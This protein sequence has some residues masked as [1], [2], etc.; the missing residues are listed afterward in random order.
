MSSDANQPD[1]AIARAIRDVVLQGS[2]S[3]REVL[4]DYAIRYCRIF[5]WKRRSLR[6]FG[7]AESFG[8]VTADVAGLEVAELLRPGPDSI[9]EGAPVLLRRLVR[10]L[11]LD[12]SRPSR[13]ERRSAGAGDGRQQAGAREMVLGADDESLLLAFRR[14]LRMRADQGL[15][16]RWATDHPEEARLL[17]CLKEFI[18]G[19]EGLHLHRDSRGGFLTTVLSDL[20]KRVLSGEEI[21]VCLEPSYAGSSRAVIA[22]LEPLLQAGAEHGGYCYLMDLVR[23]VHADQVRRFLVWCQDQAIHHGRLWVSRSGLTADLLLAKVRRSLLDL[24]GEIIAGDRHDAP[25]AVCAAWC[26]VAVEM[27]LRRYGLDGSRGTSLVQR[28]LLELRLGQHWSPE[29]ARL[30]DERTT[31]LVRRLRARWEK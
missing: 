7:F 21:R 4:A 27:V 11:D 18:R 10:A 15:E 9:D 30:H 12:P 25:P 3:A 13:R 22:R 14:I 29:S 20:T 19:A 24:A 8:D 2:S 6:R 1:P 26:E 16:R 31:Y 5:L 23:E 28:R 17:R